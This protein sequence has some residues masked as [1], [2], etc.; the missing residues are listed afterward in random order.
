VLAQA[1]PPPNDN[2]ASAHVIGPALPLSV[3]GTNVEATAQGGE[4]NVAG[5]MPI[6]TVW[7]RWTAP[8][9]QTVVY[10]LC[11]DDFS[12]PEG[13]FT[14]MEIYTGAT[15]GTLVSVAEGSVA[16]CFVRFNA[17]AGQEY[18][19]QLDYRNSQGTFNVKLRQLAP[20]SN[21]NFAAALAIGPALPV[22]VAATN[23]DATWQAGEPPALGNSASSSRSVWFNWTAPS[24]GQVRATA[25]DF[26]RNTISGAGNLTLAVYTGAT[27]GTLVALTPNNGNCE[28][29]FTAVGGTT[30]RIAFS[31]NVRGEGNFTLG[32]KSAPPPANDDFAN[33][34]TV[35]PALPVNVV[36]DDEFAGVQ[37]GE[38]DHGG[39]DPHR[40]VWYQWTPVESARV[41]IRSCSKD[42]TARVGVYTGLAVNALTTE[43]EEP[44]F[45]PYC[46]IPLDAVA[47][48]TYRIAV[49]GGQQ[50]GEYGKTNLQIRTERVPANDDFD[51]A[52]KLL[53]K[54][55]GQVTGST[56]DSSTE[57]SEPGHEP[58]SH[59]G[60][61]GSVWYRWTAGSSQ[62][63]VLSACSKT[64]PVILAVYEG[65]GYDELTQVAA[66]NSG[67]PTGSSGG[68][69]AL[70]PTKGTTYRIAVASKERDFDA[71]FTLSSRGPYL[72]ARKY[73]LKKQ[74]R[75]CR[76]IGRK[77][78]RK[79]CE[80]NAREKNA[81]LKCQN[82]LDAT[83]QAE[84]VKAARKEY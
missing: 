73:N 48:T 13:S 52:Q 55:D 17:T 1:A 78:K 61:G 34:T 26:S 11:N 58:G 80:R 63:I 7:Y 6:S 65:S 16:D 47:G 9:N 38:P 81:V 46:R 67:C 53:L 72:T 20:P 36:A 71:A 30:Y 33:A 2:F 8:A 79:R 3:P 50:D 82:K 24:N 83:Q 43:G 74:L 57:P 42:F 66:S 12:G 56:V 4:P 5:N 41:V 62:P 29:T 76:K 45:A 60:S 59:S 18:K 31:G 68:K 54:S 35:G 22:S 25:C 84:C 37:A 32:L 19:I 44:G 28:Q 69:L 70:A 49:S 23:V 64:E 75:S 10:D 40:S 51:Q 14:T 39:L 15:L 77:S 21:D 27:I